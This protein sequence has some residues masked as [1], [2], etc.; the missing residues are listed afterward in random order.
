MIV[1]QY[2]GVDTKKNTVKVVIYG[3]G[4]DLT[5]HTIIP[6]LQNYDSFQSS[7]GKDD[8]IHLQKENSL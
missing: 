3:M 4:E 5:D 7:D 6:M 1:E 8:R 2:P